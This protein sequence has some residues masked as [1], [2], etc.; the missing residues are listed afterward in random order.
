M[1][2]HFEKNFM[3]LEY[4]LPQKLRYVG[5]SAEHSTKQ[6]IFI[7]STHFVNRK[8]TGLNP[9]DRPNHKCTYFHT[10]THV[11][12]SCVALSNHYTLTMAS[13]I[14]EFYL[15]FHKTSNHEIAGEKHSV[16]SVY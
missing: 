15:Q 9:W 3:V 6:Y 8:T 12:E 4:F 11:T 7:Y 14:Q 10:I 5:T 1:Q 13:Y 16:A 2:R